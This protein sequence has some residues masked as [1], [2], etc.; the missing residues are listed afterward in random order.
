MVNPYQPSE[1]SPPWL[2]A[3][4][5]EDAEL[6]MFAACLTQVC[7]K[8]NQSL[9]TL[10]LN[11]A[12]GEVSRT[13][14]K[15]SEPFKMPLANEY[16]EKAFS[17]LGD[18]C[19]K[20]QEEGNLS[21]LQN[22]SL[23]FMNVW[24]VGVNRA[25]NEIISLIGRRC[26]NL[27]LLNVLSLEKDAMTLNERVDLR[28][29]E[30]YCGSYSARKDDERVLQSQRAGDY[31]VW[32]ITTCKCQPNSCVLIGT[33]K[34][35]F[36]ED[37]WKKVADLCT[38]V[39]YIVGDKLT[40]LGFAKDIHPHLLT[41]DARSEEDARKVCTTIENMIIKDSRFERTVPLTWIMLR[42]VLQA[43][44]QLF[45]PKSEL[46]LYANECG[47]QTSEELD[48]WLDLFQ[49]CLSIIYSPDDSVP[50]LHDSVII[51]PFKF[52]QCL[53]SLFYAEFNDEFQSDP[54]LKLHLDLMKK[55]ILTDTFAQKI[56]PNDPNTTS[57]KD[58][59][60]N[61]KCNYMLRVIMDLKISSKLDLAIFS[62]SDELHTYPTEHV[63][64]VPS[65][66]YTHSQVSIQSNSLII[67]AS[68][69]H[70]ATCNIYSE[71][72]SFVQQQEK[73]KESLKFVADE[74][75]D[76]LYLKWVENAVLG[77]DIYFRVVDGEDLV[78]LCV[79]C[80]ASKKF[81]VHESHVLLLQQKLCSIMKTICVE[82][83]HKFSQI[84]P[85][86]S[87]KLAVVSQTCLED[88]LNK[89]HVV[90]FEILGD[91]TQNNLACFTCG[92]PIASSQLS[93]HQSV[94]I[95]CAYQV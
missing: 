25:V 68:H 52:V 58:K 7:S 5:K 56:W 37:D 43:T 69:I 28:N 34:D 13:L 54:K 94:W 42:G 50:S 82:F 8:G 74:Y 60:E 17:R 87:F 31:Y 88:G 62:D 55:G 59:G 66:G 35:S 29:H 79:T 39:K 73:T 91:Q 41:V 27:I 53:D 65:L 45:L 90:P 30:R 51:H 32:S 33:Y 38:N 85:N 89:V 16:F 47:I 3:I 40:D 11:K 49:S 83:F 70:E 36:K 22:A 15:L 77:A 72:L 4:N 75:C 19:T 76:I 78:E 46:L 2:S 48:S 20:L 10:G 63:Y 93:L 84:V 12:D 6:L 71:F 24:D 95:N 21:Y 67:I 80:T 57:H 18:L 23:V 61:V 9:A 81:T 26:K 14:T 44:E 92:R 1:N 64:Y 86:M